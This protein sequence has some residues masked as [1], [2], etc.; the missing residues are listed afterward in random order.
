MSWDRGVGLCYTDVISPG[1]TNCYISIISAPPLSTCHLFSVV[2]DFSKWVIL[3]LCSKSCTRF[4]F[5]QS[6]SPSLHSAHGTAPDLDSSWDAL[7]PLLGPS[8]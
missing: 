1:I 6:K 4:H 3:P 8:L 2:T 7:T 5:T